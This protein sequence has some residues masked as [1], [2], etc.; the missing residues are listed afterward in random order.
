[1][2]KETKTL[3]K[4]QVDSERPLIIDSDGVI[5][6]QS[7]LFWVADRLVWFVEDINNNKNMLTYLDYSRN[8]NIA[9]GKYPVL[10]H[11]TGEWKNF[12]YKVINI[13]LNFIP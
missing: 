6:K 1:M 3:T 13:T 2:V 8:K 4:L 9:I 11:K 7:H 12:Q 10:S 5:Q